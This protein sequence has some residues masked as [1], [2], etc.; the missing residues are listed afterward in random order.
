ICAAPRLLDTAGILSGKKYTCFPGTPV[1]AGTKVDQ[2]VVVD[3]NVITSRGPGTALQAALKLVELIV[4][5]E[6]AV[7][8]AEKTLYK[9][10]T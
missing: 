4:S 2:D 6:E 10:V 3:G 5:P 1:S 8:Q 7:R 9:A